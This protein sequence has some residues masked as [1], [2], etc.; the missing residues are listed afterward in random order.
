MNVVGRAICQCH[1][2]GCNRNMG[3]EPRKTQGGRKMEPGGH[4]EG[5]GKETGPGRAKGG[6]GTVRV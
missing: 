4:R 2:A 5:P 1:Q 6:A 3:K